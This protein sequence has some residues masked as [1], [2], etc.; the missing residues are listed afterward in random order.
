MH[1]S[2]CRKVLNSDLVI[3][4]IL[5]LVSVLTMIGLST[6]ILYCLDYGYSV[7][8]SWGWFDKVKYTALRVFLNWLIVVVVYIAIVMI[9]CLAGG[10]TLQMLKELIG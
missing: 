6:L 3:S 10:Y 2:G 9:Y 1:G 7:I 8:S 4:L 5:G